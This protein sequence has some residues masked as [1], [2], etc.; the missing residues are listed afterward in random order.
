MEF[1]GMDIGIG[2][3]CYMDHAEYKKS[4]FMASAAPPTHALLRR[5]V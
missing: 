3:L 5:L 4:F 2:V 1:E